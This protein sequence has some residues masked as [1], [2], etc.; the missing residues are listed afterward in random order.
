MG[1]IGFLAD[2]EFHMAILEVRRGP[3]GLVA[4]L[5]FKIIDSQP[6]SS[7]MGPVPT[8]VHDFRLF[9]KR[10]HGFLACYLLCFRPNRPK[11]GFSSF[12]VATK[13]MRGKKL[14]RFV[15]VSPREVPSLLVSWPFKIF[16]VR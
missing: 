10:W 13:K 6:D 14:R 16:D 3:I 12:L 9:R 4:P 8:D 1:S 11:V 5:R 2:F 15:V 7:N